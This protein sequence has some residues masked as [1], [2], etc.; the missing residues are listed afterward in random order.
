MTLLPYFFEAAL[1]EWVLVQQARREREAGLSARLARFL[2]LQHE[3]TGEMASSA[4]LN[5]VENFTGE[6]QEYSVDEF[7]S[8][9]ETCFSRMPP[10]LNAEGQPVELTDTNKC[11]LLRL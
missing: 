6:N 1:S 7:V 11:N 5:A 4:C 3:E 2:K 9:M 10:S 8:A